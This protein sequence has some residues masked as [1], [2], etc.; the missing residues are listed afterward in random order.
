MPPR[1]AKYT[2]QYRLST[3]HILYFVFEEHEL[4]EDCKGFEILGEG[5]CII[6]DEGSVE[7]GMKE[8][9]QHCCEANQIV[10]FDGIK[11]TVVT[12]LIY[13]HDAVKDISSQNSG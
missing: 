5:P 7:G 1:N 2:I 9:S 8:K 4:A 13:H 11:V 3:W 10:T 6:S 12:G